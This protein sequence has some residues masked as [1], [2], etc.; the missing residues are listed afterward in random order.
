MKTAIINIL[1][2]VMSFIHAHTAIA[3]VTASVVVVSAVAVP[4][5]INV[6]KDKVPTKQQN[7]KISNEVVAS[8][9]PSLITVAPEEIGENTPVP[10]E[11]PI[12]T[13]EATAT[14]AP[15]LN[16]T[17]AP[18][19]K[20]T[21]KPPAKP[22][23][24]PTAKPSGSTATVVQ[25]ADPAT[26]ISWDGK[27]PII[28][29]YPDGTTGTEKRVGATYEQLPGRYN[30]VTASDVASPTPSTQVVTCS[31]CGKVPGDGTNGTCVRYS[32]LN[33]DMACPNCGDT[34]P[35]RTCHTCGQ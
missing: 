14:P 33:K 11:A 4:V 1:K 12:A 9:T 6:Y 27:S 30:T 34:I 19:L 2:T 31:Y 10:T 16:V 7:Q 29:T 24:K 20:P 22:T 15:I 18:T 8:A 5:G 13:P 23:A 3:V 26:G 21:T 25:R 35:A 28:Y 17:P 32:L